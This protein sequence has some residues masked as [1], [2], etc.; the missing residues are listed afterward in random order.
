MNV[1][2]PKTVQDEPEVVL[3]NWAIVELTSELWAG[4]TVHFVGYNSL[5]REGRVTSPLM[6]YNP[7]KKSAITRSGRHYVLSGEPGLNPD[8]SYVFETYKRINKVDT[9][10]SI[11]K[12]FY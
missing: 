5:Y 12:D 3:T 2:K 9:V 10:V 4:S 7:I 1:W 11:T 6:S 8:A